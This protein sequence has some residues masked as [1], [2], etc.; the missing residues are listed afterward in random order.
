MNEPAFLSQNDTIMWTVEADPLLRSTIMGIAVLDSTPSWDDVVARVEH[1][2]H[3]V[4]T[5]RQRVEKA[6]LHPTTL[7]W[8][9]DPMF[10]LDQHLHRVALPRG[11]TLDD[12]L[13]LSRTS[14]AS[15]F[16]RARPLWDFTLVEGLPS[17][18]SVWCMKAHHVLTDGI[19]SVQLAAHLFDLEPDAPPRSTPADEGEGPHRPSWPSRL[20]A[21]MEHDIVEAVDG[22]VHSME[23]VMPNF[24]DAVRHPLQALSAP[25]EVARSVGRL[26][27]PVASTLSPLMTERQLAG[28]YRTLVVDQLALHDAAAAHGASLND[29][30]LAGIT[31]GLRRYHHHHGADVDRLRVAMP[32]S[33]RRDSDEAGGNHVTVMRFEVHVDDADPVQRMRATREQVKGLRAERSI[34]ITNLVAGALNLMPRGVIGTMLKHVD[35]LA[36]NVPGIP[37]PLYLAGS[38][39]EQFFPFGPTAGS[40]VNVTMMSYDGR[41]CIGINTDGAAI[42]DPDDFLRHLADGFDEVINAG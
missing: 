24:V 28:A 27:R 11:A 21:A 12:A 20:I 29:A 19:G 33:I 5:L 25:L 13:Q 34:P 35:F 38:K 18:G 16:D 14:A 4:P 3:M 23:A 36:S 10:S 30:F 1:A 31:G 32:I 22:A 2:T 6:P 7:M 8:I 41:C 9:D 37:V 42:P 40:S 39:V 26:V 15:G 17:G